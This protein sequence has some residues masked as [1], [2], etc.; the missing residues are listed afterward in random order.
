[1]MYSSSGSST[2]T[3]TTDVDPSSTS[4]ALSSSL[5]SLPASK[6]QS[7]EILKAYKSASQL[8]LTRKFSDAHS[9]LEPL[10]TPPSRPSGSKDCD[11][12]VIS[13]A[14]IAR[15][16]K[17]QRIKIWVLYITLLNSIIDLDRDEGKKLFG[18]A[19]HREI[20]KSVHSGDIWETVV[21]DGY[22]GRE[23]SVDA[24]VVYNLCVCLFHSK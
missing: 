24:E 23:G 15:A 18:E 19:K 1:M 21:R 20:V 10:I 9:I 14:P 11:D 8:F 6:R 4:K 12:E 16:I 7:S 17:N 13:E 5:S 3:A 2:V 22:E